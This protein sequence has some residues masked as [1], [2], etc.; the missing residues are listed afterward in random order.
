[1]ADVDVH[2][3]PITVNSGAVAVHSDPITVDVKG[4]DNTKNTLVFET[5]QPVRAE[6]VLD[7]RLPQPFRTDSRAEVILAPIRTDST[8][9]VDIQPLVL[10]QCVTLR[11]APAPPTC[12]RQ[13][14]Q[15]HFGVTLFGLE[16]VGWNVSGESQFHIHPVTAGAHIEGG[17]IHTPHQETERKSPQ[18][19]A[20]VFGA[21][22]R[23]G[24][25]V[26]DEK[27]ASDAL[28]IRLSG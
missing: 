6:S 2:Y 18:V 17:T 21:K 23:D 15:Q 14:Y 10:D 3:D 20:S 24:E 13:P 9:A 8:A 26:E 22:E 1:M 27:L 12:I 16:I 5:P 11:F 19:M 28:R 7:L 4:L 25:T